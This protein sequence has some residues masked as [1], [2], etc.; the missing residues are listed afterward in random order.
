MARHGGGEGAT[1][2]VIIIIIINIA[3]K[4][5]F[6]VEVHGQFEHDCLHVVVLQGGCHVH[7]HVQEPQEKYLE[8]QSYL[9]K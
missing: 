8:A 9:Y 4:N 6:V 2:S 5:L 1:G 3:T 7:V